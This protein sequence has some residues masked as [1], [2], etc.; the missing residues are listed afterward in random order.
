M[1]PEY[2]E[3]LE[4]MLRRAVAVIEEEFG[5]QSKT[6]VEAKELLNALPM[7]RRCNCACGHQIEMKLVCLFCLDG[8][9]SPFTYDRTL[10]PEYDW[11]GSQ[12]LTGKAYKPEPAKEDE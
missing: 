1:T 11:G 10:F 7:S 5:A 6:V 12:T 9:H 4:S 3:Q 8:R 2:A